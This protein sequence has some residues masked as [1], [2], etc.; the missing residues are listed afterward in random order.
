MARVLETGRF[1]D[2]TVKGVER[3]RFTWTFYVG[4]FTFTLTLV[5]KDRE[6][7]HQAR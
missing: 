7:R 6:N 1:S 5:V 4:Q 2:T 3:M